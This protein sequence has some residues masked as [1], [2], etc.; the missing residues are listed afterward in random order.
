MK[1]SDPVTAAPVRVPA[2][3]SH[4]RTPAELAAYRRRELARFAKDDRLSR[5]EQYGTAT[6]PPRL[7]DLY[8]TYDAA[9][10]HRPAAGRSFPAVDYGVVDNRRDA[11]A[12][13]PQTGDDQ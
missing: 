10:R 9:E 7:G 11:L 5:I 4:C 13:Y 1:H 12:A 3:R 8:E 6:A 2:L